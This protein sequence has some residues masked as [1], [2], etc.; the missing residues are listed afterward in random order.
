MA[1]NKDELTQKQDQPGGKALMRQPD[2]QQGEKGEG[3][4]QKDKITDDKNTMPGQQQGE[5]GEMTAQMKQGTDIECPSC[6]SHN[7]QRTGDQ[8]GEKGEGDGQQEQSIH[9]KCRDCGK[10]FDFNIK[11]QMEKKD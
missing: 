8:Q 3:K 9:C 2:D 1:E 5:K 4:Q 6:H 7:I 11:D 10:Q